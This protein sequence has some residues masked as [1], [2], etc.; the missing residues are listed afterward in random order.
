MLLYCATTA[1]SYDGG[2]GGGGGSGGGG[3]GSSSK[4]SGAG[5]GG[6]DVSNVPVTSGGSTAHH[7]LLPRRTSAGLNVSHGAVVNLI[8][9]PPP[10]ST[11]ATVG[12]EFF[13][14][15]CKVH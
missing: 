7:L 4:T 1:A 10:G 12:G 13:V 2:G 11:V 9:G 6:V 3:A 14:Y 8:L 15:F 5:S